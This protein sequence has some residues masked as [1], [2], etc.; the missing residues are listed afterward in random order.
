M[1]NN[2]SELQTAV[3]SLRNT[4]IAVCFFSLGVNLLMLAI[5]LYMMQLYD[6]VLPNNSVDTL[7]MLTLIAAVAMMTYAALEAVRNFILQKIS[8]WLNVQLS[9]PVL[10]ASIKKAKT[11]MKRPSA[12]GLRDVAALRGFLSS[13][14]IFPILDAPWSPIFIAVLF[15]IH[16]YIGFVTL[17]GGLVLFAFIFVNELATRRL[18]SEQSEISSNIYDQ[19]QAALRNADAIEAMGMRDAFIKRWQSRNAELLSRHTLSGSRTATISGI[20]RFIRQMLQIVILATAAILV[21]QQEITAGALIASVLLM[22]RAVAPVDGAID[23]WKSIQYARKSYDRI[24]ALLTGSSREKVSTT[25][26]VPEGELKVRG[27]SYKHHK[28][29]RSL[30]RDVRF[31]AYPGNVFGLIGPSGSGKS[32]LARLLV[33]NLVPVNGTVRLDGVDISDWESG[34]LGRYIGYLPQNPEL[35]EGTVRE[36]IARMTTGETEAVIAA[37]KRAGAHDMICRLPNSYETLIS[38]DGKSL[39]GGQRQ[40]V[41][42]ARAFYGNPKLIILDEADANLDG[43]GRQALDD[44][45]LHFKQQRATIVL[46]THKPD[47]LTHADRIL[48]LQKARLEVL[49]PEYMKETKTIQQDG[50]LRLEEP[51]PA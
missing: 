14:A 29:E 4:L 35:L 1:L 5:P 21:M 12:Q 50:P 13:S 30:F 51:G 41:A 20:V 49:K 26:P 48:I 46:I 22:R 44:A 34:D 18:N 42:L 24:Q 11:R 16:P 15:L 23:S 33:G 32:T 45:I 2:M 25:Y 17:I 47:M 40:Q 19:A 7:Y 8:T 27:L 36:N 3:S 10:N 28:S 31:S 37:A 39:S 43:D 9:A 38:E 6:R